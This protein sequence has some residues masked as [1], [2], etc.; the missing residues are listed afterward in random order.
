MSQCM[1]DIGLVFR[2]EVVHVAG[3]GHVEYAV[4]RRHLVPEQIGLANDSPTVSVV[5]SR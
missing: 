4:M 5:R 3:I 1:G 2:K